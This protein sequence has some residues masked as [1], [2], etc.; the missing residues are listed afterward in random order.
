[1]RA[2]LPPGLL[3][4]LLIPASLALP[5][6]DDDCNACS[7]WT[8][9][10]EIEPNDLPAEANWLGTL[11]PGDALAIHGRITQLGPDL[12]DGFA[13]RSGAPIYVE[14]ALWADQPGADLDLCLYDP[15]TGQ[16][17]YCWETPAQPEVGNFTIFGAG[18]DVHLVVSSFLGDSDYRLEVAVYTPCCPPDEAQGL[19][20]ADGMPGP[21]REG[22]DA[23][24][25]LYLPS[26]PTARGEPV[27]L[28]LPGE[29]VEVDLA[30]GELRREPLLLLGADGR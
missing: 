13:L 23:L 6:C 4:L 16:Y 25:S 28:V 11:Y 26:G 7:G 12:L 3:A 1:M 19:I 10:Y 9:A 14:F 18:K 29:L 27:R 21:H 2:T 24:W 17:I 5:G 22:T 20:Q 30:S 15:D 8:D